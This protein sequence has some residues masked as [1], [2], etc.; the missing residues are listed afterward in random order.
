MDHVVASA[1]PSHIDTS[2]PVPHAVLERRLA[3]LQAWMSEQG[4]AA[5]VVFGHGSALAMATKSHGNLR[6]LID[7]DADYAQSALVLPATGAPALAVGG[8]FPVLWAQEQ[9]WIPTVKL[10]KG[11][12][13]GRE[14]LGLLPAG[15]TR[16]G[17]VGRDEI[18]LGLW[19][20]LLKGGAADWIDCTSEL[21]R[22]R[23]VKDNTAIAYHSGS[24]VFQIQAELEHH[25]KSRGAE[26]VRTWL[27]VGPAPDRCRF[28]RD[29]NRNVPQEG[30]QVLLGIM[31]I[32][33]G[34]WGHGIRTGAIGRPTAAA[35]RLFAEVKGMH[36]AM[37]AALRPGADLSVVGALGTA[38]PRPGLFQFRS[39]HA[40][41]HSYE[42]P[43]GT[44][45][46]PQ[47]YEGAAAPPP[48][49]A[50]AQPGMVFELHPNIFVADEGGASIG[51]MALV[52]DTGAEFLTTHPRGLLIF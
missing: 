4:L 38:T 20:E 12:A 39:G 22:R 25:A 47:P 51:D 46:F 10:G 30:D 23:A 14:L 35:E 11:P 3:S 29:E 1:P 36:D 43:A 37:F 49:P 52:T 15:A 13:L 28:T 5:M 7:W 17:I 41:G 8:I 9:N 21:V 31:L 40:I 6:H 32:L 33:H 2:R 18:P 19:T 48:K 42:D 44:P 34:H 16:I 24:Q 50:M 45:E 26:L 27:T